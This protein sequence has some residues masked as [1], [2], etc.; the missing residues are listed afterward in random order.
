M[1][2]IFEKYIIKHQD[3]CSNVEYEELALFFRPEKKKTVSFK[4]DSFL[5]MVERGELL[6]N[7]Y[8]K[9]PNCFTVL[10]FKRN[11][12]NVSVQT[13]GGL[14]KTSWYGV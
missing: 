12:V 13:P 5:R 3:I 6:N 8:N 1:V 14:K 9:L 4:R 7:V 10:S 11:L 2:D